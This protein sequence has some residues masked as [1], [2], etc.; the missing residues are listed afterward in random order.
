MG[1]AEHG[2]GTKGP[3]SL[4]NGSAISQWKDN[5]GNWH[6]LCVRQLARASAMLYSL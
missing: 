4:A 2:P 5:K 1:R 6:L 3:V